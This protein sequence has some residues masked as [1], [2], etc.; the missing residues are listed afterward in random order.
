[1]RIVY[2]FWKCLKA[3]YCSILARLNDTAQ[4]PMFVA[5]P[6]SSPASKMLT[7]NIDTETNGTKT[8]NDY[9]QLYWERL[10]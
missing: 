2:I 6:S 1:M 4:L 10:R 5:Y 8:N 3:L 9:V 7:G